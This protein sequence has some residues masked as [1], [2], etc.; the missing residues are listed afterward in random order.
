MVRRPPAA[1]L[2]FYVDGSG[3]GDDSALHLL[4][5]LLRAGYGIAWTAPFWS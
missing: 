2:D 3:K 4:K 5:L 1:E